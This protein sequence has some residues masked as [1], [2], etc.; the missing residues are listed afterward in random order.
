MT[1]A[2]KIAW[3]RKRAGLSQEELAEK[4]GVSRQA[5]SKWELGDATP[6]VGKLLQLARTFGVTTDWLLGGEDPAEE[7][8]PPQPETKPAASWVDAVPGAVGRLLR[9][10]GWLFGVRLAVSGGL[11]AALGLVGRYM[12]RT[13]ISNPFGPTPSNPGVMLC[14]F[15]AAVGAV[16]LIIG[17]AVIIALYPK[18]R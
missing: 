1:L 10:Y 16:M 11:T 6:E 3:C 4:V 14:T 9:Q 15:A 13:F 2:E 18:K 7:N 12:F 8:A 5:V 17:V